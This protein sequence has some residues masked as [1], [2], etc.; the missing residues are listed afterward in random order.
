M[1]CL[2]GTVQRTLESAYYDI[3]RDCDLVRRHRRRLRARAIWYYVRHPIKWARIPREHEMEMW[4]FF[5]LDHWPLPKSVRDAYQAVRKFD[6]I[7]YHVLRD[8]L[9]HAELFPST[10]EAELKHT[11]FAG[12]SVDD[13]AKYYRAAKLETCILAEFPSEA[14]AHMFIEDYSLDANRARSLLALHDLKRHMYVRAF[15]FWRPLSLTLAAAAII[16]NTFP[17]DAILALGYNESQYDKFLGGLTAY[18]VLILAIL[19]IIR[20]LSVPIWFAS[21]NRSRSRD[22]EFCHRMLQYVVIETDYSQGSTEARQP[23][24][25]PHEAEAS[26]A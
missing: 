8:V 3:V 14:L 20:V 10:L 11:Q 4:H 22:Y 19:F 18:L 23:Q 17:K 2:G 25:A 6:R 26:G 1:D 5:I 12:W 16:G 24:T 7:P 13:F 21:G 9:R 15:R